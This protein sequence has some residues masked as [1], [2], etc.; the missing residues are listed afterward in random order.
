[1]RV[2]VA[3]EGRPSPRIAQVGGQRKLNEHHGSSS[4]Q[5]RTCHLPLPTQVAHKTKSVSIHSQLLKNLY[6]SNTS[7]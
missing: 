1:M 5:C 3:L 6:D 4:M 7:K 2:V